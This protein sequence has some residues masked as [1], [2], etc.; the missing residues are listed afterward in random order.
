MDEQYTPTTAE[1]REGYVH[2]TLN[3]VADAADFDSWLT[4]HDREV[5]EKA[6]R[7]AAA[8]F[9][10]G[11]A[12]GLEPVLNTLAAKLLTKRADRYSSPAT[13]IRQS[14]EGEQR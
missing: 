12:A 14:I 6:L 11:A 7:E 4:A 9:Q 3:P 5:A 2:L 13:T 1:I 8:D 10:S